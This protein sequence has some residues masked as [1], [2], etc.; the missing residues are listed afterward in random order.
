MRAPLPFSDDLGKWFI[1]GTIA[2]PVPQWRHVERDA[3]VGPLGADL[4]QRNLNQCTLNQSEDNKQ[5]PPV[6]LLAQAPIRLRL[7]VAGYRYWV[8]P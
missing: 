3:Q 5:P 2:A 7:L 1:A 6:R 8:V 4:V